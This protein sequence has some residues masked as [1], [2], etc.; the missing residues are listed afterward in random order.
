MAKQFFDKGTAIKRRVGDDF[1]ADMKRDPRGRI[2][3]RQNADQAMR[4]K[5]AFHQARG[6][7]RFSIAAA[8]IDGGIEGMAAQNAGGVQKFQNT[9]NRARGVGAAGDRLMSTIGSASR[10]NHEGSMHKFDSKMQTMDAIGGAV[11]TAASNYGEASDY[12]KNKQ[13][14]KQLDASIASNPDIF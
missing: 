3:A 13:M 14:N 12:Y 4:Q 6:R 5:E 1:L 11:I 9:S 10:I 8:S 2:A 7:N